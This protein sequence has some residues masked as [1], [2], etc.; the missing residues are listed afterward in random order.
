MLE[1]LHQRED[2]AHNL[3]L[4][5]VRILVFPPVTN[6]SELTELDRVL[7]LLLV[8]GSSGSGRW[9]FVQRHGRK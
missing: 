9:H 3:I 6:Y 2:T 4:L 1:A 7:H 8:L 5:L